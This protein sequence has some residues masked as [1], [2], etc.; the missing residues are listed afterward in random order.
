MRRGA[1]ESISSKKQHFRVVLSVPIRSIRRSLTILWSLRNRLP[2]NGS[3]RSTTPSEASLRGNS[4][5]VDAVDMNRQASEVELA[6]IASLDISAYAA[7]TWGLK[8]ESK[9]G[10]D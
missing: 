5:A 10:F 9:V 6:P 4:G 1:L 2:M 3:R 8:V 7:Y